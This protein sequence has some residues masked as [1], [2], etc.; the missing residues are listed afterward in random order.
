[1]GGFFLLKRNI[2]LQFTCTFKVNLRTEIWKTFVTS[3]VMMVLEYWLL[4]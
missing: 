4:A 1:M 3:I 2:K